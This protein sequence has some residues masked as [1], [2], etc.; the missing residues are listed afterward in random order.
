MRVEY[1]C[2][3]CGQ[4]MGDVE[5]PGWSRA[6]AELHCGVAQLSAVERA[7][8]VSYNEEQQVMTVQSVCDYCQ[9][10]LESHPEVLVEGKLLQ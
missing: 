10:A 4:S 8:T 9:Q 2:R 1:R 7:E 5:R 6:D 3:H